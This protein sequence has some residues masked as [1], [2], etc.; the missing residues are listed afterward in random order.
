MKCKKEL[1][2]LKKLKITFKKI[3][4]LNLINLIIFK[5]QFLNNK[6]LFIPK[7]NIKIQIIIY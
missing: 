6:F 1:F 4:A 3:I 5:N 2:Y 7:L